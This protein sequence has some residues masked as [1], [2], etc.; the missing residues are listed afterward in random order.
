MFPTTNSERKLM[1]QR[2]TT[3]SRHV[4]APEGIL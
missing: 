1:E 4:D 2:Q 3:N